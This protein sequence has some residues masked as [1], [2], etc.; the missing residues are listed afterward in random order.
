MNGVR[1]RKEVVGENIVVAKV[2]RE[3]DRDVGVW[4]LSGIGRYRVM[5]LIEDIDGHEGV[6]VARDVAHNTG[7]EAK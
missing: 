7:M 5:S 6:T 2:L 4:I 3:S 1:R